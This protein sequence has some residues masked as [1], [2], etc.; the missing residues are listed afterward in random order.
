MIPGFCN[1]VCPSTVG[2]EVGK[3]E[4]VVQKTSSA[5]YVLWADDTE[6]KILPTL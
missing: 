6:Y 2:A 5:S 3:T 1:N 4:F